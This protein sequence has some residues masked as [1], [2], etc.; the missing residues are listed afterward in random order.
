MKRIKAKELPPVLTDDIINTLVEM[1]IEFPKKT[2]DW[3]EVSEVLEER[4][5]LYIILDKVEQIQR[6]KENEKKASMTEQEKAEEAAKWE[7]IRNNPDPNKFYGNMGQ[8]ETPQEY[9]NRYGVWPP[10]YDKDGN[11]IDE[12]QS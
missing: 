3:A 9:K 5:Q 12:N 4:G 7:R 10:G 1:A 2:F 6:E 11:K 8:P